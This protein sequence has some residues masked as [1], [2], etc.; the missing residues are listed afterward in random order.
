MSQCER[1]RFSFCS[2]IPQR[3]SSRCLGLVWGPGIPEDLA[4]SPDLHRG[5]SLS[6]HTGQA[7]LRRCF[8][9]GLVTRPP[10]SFPALCS[11]WLTI[12]RVPWMGH[13]R[14]S[15]QPAWFSR[16]CIKQTGA[17]GHHVPQCHSGAVPRLGPFLGAPQTLRLLEVRYLKTVGAN[18]S[19]KQ[20]TWSLLLA[21]SS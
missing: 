12:W 2:F 19:G 13:N 9:M 17:T 15:R 4:W 6:L 16:L 7:K 1:Q 5:V 18:P 20:N 10:H 3:L 14:K 11:T 21:H 8:P